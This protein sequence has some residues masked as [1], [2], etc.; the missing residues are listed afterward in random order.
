M[1]DVL[2]IELKIKVVDTLNKSIKSIL[3]DATLRSN[4]TIV[5]GES[6]GSMFAEVIGTWKQEPSIQINVAT[7]SPEETARAVAQH[8]P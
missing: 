2:K 8:L 3:G 4:G 6:D 7:T 1:S 5:T